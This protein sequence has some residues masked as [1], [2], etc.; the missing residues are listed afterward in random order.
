MAHTRVGSGTYDIQVYANG[1]WRSVGAFDDRL[2]AIGEAKEM[3]ENPRYLSVKVIKEQFDDVRGL[4][5]QQTIFRSASLRDERQELK[6]KQAE[7]TYK[8]I[9]D[10]HR[11]KIGRE[12][13]LREVQK[14]E[15]RERWSATGFTLNMT[16]RFLVILGLGIGALYWLLT[17][18]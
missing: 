4:Y 10:R 14:A 16:F 1:R 8:R 12:R 2:L 18:Y 9:G 11:Q 5:V 13:A 17:H 7:D 6:Q 3:A 15:R